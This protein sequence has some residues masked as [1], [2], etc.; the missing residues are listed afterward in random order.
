MVLLR[1]LKLTV[2][3]FDTHEL[4]GHMWKGEADCAGTFA[5]G[6]MPLRMAGRET[7]CVS[8]VHGKSKFAG[9]WTFRTTI[10]ASVS[11]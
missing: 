8:V 10:W 4:N 3:L 11:M 9:L 6:L 2:P 1:K 7:S 5:V